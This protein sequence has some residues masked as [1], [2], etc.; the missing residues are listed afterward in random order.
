MLSLLFSRVFF[1]VFANSVNII[2]NSVLDLFSMVFLMFSF[3][4]FFLP[5]GS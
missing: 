3:S 1:F 4:S 5:F 2:E